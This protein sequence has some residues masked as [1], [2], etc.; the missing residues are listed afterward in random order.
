M[1]KKFI[2]KFI[3]FLL[4]II[5]LLLLIIISNPLSIISTYNRD[6]ISGNNYIKQRQKYHYN[7]FIFGS[8]RTLAYP[9]KSWQKHLSKNAIPFK[10]DASS[11]TIFGIHS[12]MKYI[13]EQK[14]SIKNVLLIFCQKTTFITTEDSKGIL[15]IKH[16]K[17]A[18]TSDLKFYIKFI[19]AFFE[20]KFM[21]SFI[22]YFFANKPLIEK[23]KDG[24]VTKLDTINNDLVMYLWEKELKENSQ[25]Y[26]SKRKN[27]FYSRN[28]ITRT[29]H[30]Q[31]INAKQIMMLKEIKQIFDKH[32]T[33]YKIVISPLYNQIYFN[34][35]DIK[36]LQAIF[37]AN[38]IYDYSGI[39]NYTNKVENYYELSHYR[40]HVGEAIM[41]EIYK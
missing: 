37:G 16:P 22:L 21:M 24:V 25:N 10:F 3:L 40:P 4:P 8:S 32:K 18:K 17:I 27:I 1:L 26:Y 9:V 41:S 33:K 31:E 6:F 15:F 23:F 11:E 2:Y 38:N 5:S 19:R 35:I 28:T 29:Y 12:K 14:D 36:F 13:D 20:R 39:N 7:S 34:K 30:K